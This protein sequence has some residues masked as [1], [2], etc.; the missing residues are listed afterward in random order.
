MF[1]SVTTILSDGG[2]G[3]DMSHLPQEY[4]DRGTFVHKCM[5][6]RAW[7]CDMPEIPKDWRGYVDAGLQFWDD[8]KPQPVLVEPTLVHD[9]LGIVGHLDLFSVE[10]YWH[11]LWDYKTGSIPEYCPAQ[12]AGYEILVRRLFPDIGEIRHTAIKL[13][14]NGKYQL[15]EYTD[16]EKAEGM[17]QFMDSYYGYFERRDVI[18]THRR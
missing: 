14:E 13:M 12:L 1:P 16:R 2:V 6:L 5:E 8:I 7:E 18:W 17:R 15:K 3:F 10:R 4:S 11:D 9:L